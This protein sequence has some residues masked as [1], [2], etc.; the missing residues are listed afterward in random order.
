[1]RADFRLLDLRRFGDRL[2]EVRSDFVSQSRQHDQRQFQM[3]V[4][5]EPKAQAEFGV[6]FEQRVRPCRTAALGVLGP[7]RDRQIA[8]VDRGAAGGVGDLRAV[9]EQ[10]A[11]QLEIGRLT[12]ATA[13]AGELEQRLQELH[14]ADV[15]EI[16]PRA[17]VD[18]QSF[19][20]RDVGRS[21]SSSGCLS[22]RLIALTLASRGLVSGQASTHRP[23]PVQSST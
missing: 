2:G 19:K 8:A 20:E 23:Q 13:G 9:A 18:R 11:E 6:V 4:G 15:G 17:I 5:G 1:M 14:A 12:A 22:A 10:L 7:R 3:L 21:A 16:D